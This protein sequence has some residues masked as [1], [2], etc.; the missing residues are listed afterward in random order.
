MRDRVFIDTNVL[1]YIYSADEAQK[2]EIAVN[3]VS[4]RTCVISVQVLNEFSSV[5]LRK[6]R[7][8]A[9]AVLQNGCVTVYSE[10]M[11]DGQS[12]DGRLT[13]S[14]IFKNREQ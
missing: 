13:I 10:D 8:P 4:G 2:R 9:D 5:F 3:A 7:V 12:I 11:Q 14:N 1:I 6:L